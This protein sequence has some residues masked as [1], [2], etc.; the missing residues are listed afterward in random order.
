MYPPII[1]PINPA[2][3]ELADNPTINPGAI[4][5]FPAIE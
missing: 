2:L 1:P 5:G 3:I 4:P